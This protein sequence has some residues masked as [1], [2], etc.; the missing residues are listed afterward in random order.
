M[1]RR[2]FR[3]KPKRKRRRKQTGMKVKHK[4]MLWGAGAITAFF[5][6]FP[7]YFGALHQRIRGG[8]S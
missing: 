4:N 7:T 6:V 2:R 5:L 3:Y 8:Q 1:A